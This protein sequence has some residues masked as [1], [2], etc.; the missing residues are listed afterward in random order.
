MNTTNQETRERYWQ[1]FVK[2]CEENNAPLR[3]H[4]PSGASALD[5]NLGPNLGLDLRTTAVFGATKIPRYADPSNIT[6]R[7][8]VS[9]ELWDSL[10]IEW[11]NIK[12]KFDGSGLEHKQLDSNGKFPSGQQIFLYR[13]DTDPVDESDWQQQFKWF[14]LNFWRFA[15]IF[16]ERFCSSLEPFDQ[17]FEFGKLGD[18]TDSTYFEKSTKELI[19]VIK[20]EIEF[21]DKQ[22]SHLSRR[23][24]ELQDT[25]SNYEQILLRGQP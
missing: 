8:S 9:A 16:R 1:K 20:K 4:K 21:L 17:P 6:I 13:K 23:R 19:K 18:E 14:I 7:I 25:L 11:D 24:S 12:S 22:I 5:V 3:A 2:T 15:E 10:K